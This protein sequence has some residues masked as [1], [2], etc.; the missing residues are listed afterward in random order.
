MAA[1]HNEDAFPTHCMLCQ[2][3]QENLFERS[4]GSC[5]QMVCMHNDMTADKIEMLIDSSFPSD[6]EDD[7]DNDVSNTIPWHSVDMHTWL[8]V[9]EMRKLNTKNGK[10][11]IITLQKRDKSI[12]ERGLQS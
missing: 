7:D 6:D 2:E 12:V 4:N 8:K 9:L 3:E 5:G 10:A 11:M 1:I